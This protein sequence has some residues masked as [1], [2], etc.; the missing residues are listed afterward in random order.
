MKTAHIALT[1]L[2]A[3]AGATAATLEGVTMPDTQQVD[4]KTLTLN[5]MGLRSKLMIKV[6]V[7]G[8]YLAAKS[9]DANAILQSDEPK[10]MSLEFLRDVSKD[11]M[12]EAY[13][14]AFDLN[15][16][17]AKASL[18]SEIGRLMA[19]FEPLKKGDKMAFTYTPGQGT[20]MVVNGQDKVTIPG[21]EFGRAMCAC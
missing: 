12:V 6:Y 8:L 7:A 1:L 5:G 20:T 11:Q 3:C 13:T 10:R 2:L 14:E 16:P 4:G 19:A 17:S 9:R 18:G 15:A 21:K